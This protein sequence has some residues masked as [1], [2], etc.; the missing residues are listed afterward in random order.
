[1]Y[2]RTC[3]KCTTTFECLFEDMERSICYACALKEICPQVAPEEGDF[4]AAGLLS[5]ELTEQEYK[6]IQEDVR[7]AE[8]GISIHE[9]DCEDPEE[10]FWDERC[11]ECDVLLADE[12]TICSDCQKYHG[13]PDE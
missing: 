11:R 9:Y 8:L 6:W 13:I 4:N 1:M 3:E 5:G 12:K 7:A 10:S 2:I